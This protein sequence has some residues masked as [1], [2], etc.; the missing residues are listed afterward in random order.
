MGKALPGGLVDDGQA[1][2][3]LAIG[4]RVEDEVVGP[5]EVRTDDWQRTWPA[6]GDPPPRTAARQLQTGLAPQAMR[7]MP[8]ELMSLALQADADAPI[9]IAR[10]CDENSFM[11]SITGRS[12]T[13]R[14][15]SQPSVERE[16]PSSLQAHHFR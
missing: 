5:D 8:A 7:A 15:S 13:G 11:A 6:A 1:F 10:Y 4:T 9:A 16:M 2:E 12:L 3:L 14:R